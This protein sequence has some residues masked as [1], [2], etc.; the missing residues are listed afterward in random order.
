MTESAASKMTKLCTAVAAMGALVGLVVNS[1][2]PVDAGTA[3]AAAPAAVSAP[4]AV[5]GN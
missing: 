1:G 4:A 2:H 5:F 3:A